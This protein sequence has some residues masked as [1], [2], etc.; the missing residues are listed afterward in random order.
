M[1]AAFKMRFYGLERLP[2][3]GGAIL[4]PNHVSVL[5]PIAVSL[6]AARRGRAVRFLALAELFEQGW[7]GWGLRHSN[8]IPLR[9]GLG[10]W[11]AIDQVAEALRAGSLGGMSPEG[12]VGDGMSLQP[13]QRG[14]ARIALA[15][16]VPLVPV[17]VWG[18]QRRWPKEGLHWRP[19]AR[20]ALAVAVGAAI[21]VS[22]NPRDRVQV[23]ALTERLMSELQD[24]VTLAGR[25]AGEDE[26]VGRG[27]EDP[28]TDTATPLG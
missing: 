24:A 25:L 11:T 16:G 26:T 17:G 13:G 5:D 14:A 22:G 6:A 20:P 3:R 23:L 1:R 8:Q 12:T 2:E 28:G 18:T 19:P 27:A 9:R 4:A 7:V 21:A 10:D 15:A